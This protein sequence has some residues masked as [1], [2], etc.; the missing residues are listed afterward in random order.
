MK[1]LKNTKSKITK[2][3]NG[4]N[5]PYLEITE[6]VLMH[7]NFINNGYQQD[8]RDLHIFFLINHLINYQIFYLKSNIFL[9]TFDSEFSYIEIW[10]LDQNSKSLEI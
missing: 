10:F 8:S 6:V 7:C 3:E 2:D 5:V 4:E 9:K 1:L